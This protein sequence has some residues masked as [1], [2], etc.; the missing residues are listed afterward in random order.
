MAVF[1]AAVLSGCSDG[2]GGSDR[3]TEQGGG[4]ATEVCGAFAKDAPA[5][6]ALESVMG[7][8]RFTD[9]L[10]EPGKAL[11]EL[12]AASRTPLA[13]TYRPQPV[14]YCWLLPAQKGPKDL[15][16]EVNATPEV[17]AVDPMLADK[18]T[19]FATGARAYSSAGL[20]KLYFMC[21]LEAPAHAITVET[22]VRGPGTVL[23]EDRQ[24]RVQMATLANAAA[25]QISEELGCQ[26][27][28]LATGVP[29]AVAS[30]SSARD[31]VASPEQV[32]QEADK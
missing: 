14:K 27:D 23:G 21:R 16:V 15:Q 18:A 3:A 17:P 28:E 22:S 20:A 19:Y 32:H 4:G 10:S 25:R 31:P 12:R 29:P 5:S 26:G 6:A 1:L 13:R 9:D 11:D 2:G 7:A 24:R 8:E 30:P